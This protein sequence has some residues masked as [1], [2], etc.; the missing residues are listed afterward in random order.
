MFFI[1]LNDLILH[2]KYIRLTV[3]FIEGELNGFRYF[4]IILLLMLLSWVRSPDDISMWFWPKI[5]IEFLDFRSLINNGIA[6]Q[7]KIIRT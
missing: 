3:H 4:K 2:T 6:K 1:R 5:Y 7:T